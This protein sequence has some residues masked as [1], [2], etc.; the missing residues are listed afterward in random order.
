MVDKPLVEYFASPA[1]ASERLDVAHLSL[2]THAHRSYHSLSIGQQFQAGLA[3][4]LGYR[5]A[6]VDEFT[7]A[8][9][10]SLAIAVARAVRGYIA[11][12]NVTA[13]GG[14]RAQFVFVGCHE[15][16]VDALLPDWTYTT[17][18]NHFTTRDKVNESS[19]VQQGATPRADPAWLAGA[20]AEAN[21]H[22]VED[23]SGHR[24]TSAPR[25]ACT[26]TT[27]APVETVA[28]PVPVIPLRLEACDRAWWSV[29]SDH[30][31]KSPILSPA[32]HTYLLKHTGRDLPVGFVAV[33]RHNGAKVNGV[34]PFRAHRTV[35]LPAWQ[36]LGI[37]SRLSDAAAEIYRRSVH[38]ALNIASPF[39]N[40]APNI[41]ILDVFRI[42][43]PYVPGAASKTRLGS[44]T[45]ETNTSFYL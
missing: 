22:Q 35:V 38:H 12:S 33:I 21:E 44:R 34:Q 39:F 43:A 17:G 36:G 18:N 37:G 1:E 13:C 29:F 10:R 26:T 5:S 31:Y 40:H 25:S 4:V 7:N 9:D 19:S 27:Q 20:S 32:A 15:D 14:S 42:P 8:L 11:S 16:I 2:A 23:D 45:K 3:R 41:V 28:V 24:H 30:H 6:V